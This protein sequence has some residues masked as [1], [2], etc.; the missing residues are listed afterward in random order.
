MSIP[1]YIVRYP[2][3]CRLHPYQP[4]TNRT[5]KYHASSHINRKK[6]TSSHTHCSQ[7]IP[8]SPPIDTAF[9]P[10]ARRHTETIKC[11]TQQENNFPCSIG[12]ETESVTESEATKYLTASYS[13]LHK[14]QTS[15]PKPYKVKIN[16]LLFLLSRGNSSLSTI[17]LENRI[18]L[19]K[20][21]P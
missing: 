1:Y 21:L 18:L 10:S 11:H 6:P 7:T 8:R 4:L 20:P 17:Y 9:H 2:I 3:L 15:F 14:S 12:V 13:H 16:F 19:F 5:K